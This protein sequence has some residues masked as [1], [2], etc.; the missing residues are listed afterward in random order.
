M[1]LRCLRTQRGPQRPHPRPLAGA[2]RPPR[3]RPGRPGARLQRARLAPHRPRH[4][5][6]DRRDPPGAATSRPW[7]TWS[8]PDFGALP[9]LPPV[10]VEEDRRLRHPPPRRSRRH[11]RPGHGPDRPDRRPGLRR[12]VPSRRTAPWAASRWSAA[13]SS[14]PSPGPPSRSREPPNPRPPGVPLPRPP[15]I[16]PA[17]DPHPPYRCKWRRDPRP[18]GARART[19][20][21]RRALHGRRPPAH[22]LAPGRRASTPTL[23]P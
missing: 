13:G 19:R 20:R 16:R 17:G 6:R 5:P 8:I 11:R 1:G 3:R 9:P 15:R 23:A 2:A 7:A 22:R 10:A 21:R 18:R 4:P 12:T 14:T